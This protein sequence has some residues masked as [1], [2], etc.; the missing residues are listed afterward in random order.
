M[1]R[2]FW[3][4]QLAGFCSLKVDVLSTS[5]TCVSSAPRCARL[6]CFFWAARF[7]RGHWLLFLSLAP[8]GNAPRSPGNACW[9]VAY[10]PST[11]R[12]CSSSRQVAHLTRTSPERWYGTASS[13]VNEARNRVIWL[14]SKPPI[15][16]NI[17]TQGYPFTHTIYKHI[18]IMYRNI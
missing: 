15:C 2:I 5:H 8:P 6:C 16:I 7:F 18:D 13:F 4:L 10:H 17:D 9:G 3:K 12:W 1:P 14:G 11:T